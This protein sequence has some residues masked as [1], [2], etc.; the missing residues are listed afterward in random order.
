MRALF[1]CI[2]LNYS[3]FAFAGNG[4]SNNDTSQMNITDD[5]GRKQGRWIILGKDQPEKGYPMDGKISEGIFKD[6]RKNG[7]WVIYYKDGVTPK[8]IANFENNRPHGTFEKFYP[9]GKL[10]EQ[11][12]FKGKRYV[13]SLKRYNTEG[14]L[15][16]EANYSQTGHESGE[17]KYY[18]DNGNPEFIYIAENS[19]P[20]GKATRYW[21][22]GDIKEEIVYSP[23][24]M[25][26]NTSGI[27]EP[28]EP[29][30]E[31]KKSSQRSAPKVKNKD[32]SY[33]PNGYNTIYNKNQE[34]HMEGE[35]KNNKL[36][37]GRLLIYD[38]NGLLLKIEVYKKGVYHS[39]GQL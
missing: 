7:E 31:E 37:D 26:S 5:Q 8:V 29:L 36:W 1:I 22:N 10:K 30:V 33:Q 34:L 25:V 20:K 12:S 17:V 3:L 35:F 9:N 6:D 32:E 21:N 14:V 23:E 16:Y 15:V 18:H 28:I 38:E 39:D 13:D 24:G 27:I 11:G 2:V 4:V 19:T